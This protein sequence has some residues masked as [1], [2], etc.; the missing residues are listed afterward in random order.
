MDKTEAAKSIFNKYAKAYQEQFMDISRYHDTLD[1]FCELIVKPDAHILDIACG[2]GNITK[3]LLQK[4]PHCQLLGID[5]APNMIE[6][7][8]KNNPTAKFSI[9]D[10]RMI[11]QLE[12]QY[13]GIVC[14]FG[15]PYLAKEEA[16]Q[17]IKDAADLL[18]P[19]G[20]L[21]LS[22]ID[23]NYEQSGW[24]SS[25]SGKSGA[26]YTYYYN[27]NL[28]SDILKECGFTPQE[29][30]HKSYLNGKGEEVVDLVMLS[31]LDE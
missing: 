16:T 12:S 8:Q 20:L 29:S 25:S 24:K 9:L 7:A 11:N 6:L 22:T 30:W 21:Y 1:H 15:L 27:D 17:M 18:L 19:K 28:L 5:I 10:A 13:D 3:Y 26:T 4:K 23:G 2:P 14:G 31:T